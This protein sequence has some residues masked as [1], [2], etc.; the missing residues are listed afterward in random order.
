MRQHRNRGR[1]GRR[2]ELRARPR[3]AASRVLLMPV[4]IAVDH[5]PLAVIDAALP[6]GNPMPIAPWPMKPSIVAT[7]R[8][9]AGALRLVARKPLELVK[10]FPL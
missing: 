4:R 2:V 1:P 6:V 5:A 9:V 8:T 3:D 7:M 10:S